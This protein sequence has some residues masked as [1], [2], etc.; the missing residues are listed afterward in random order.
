MQSGDSAR[1]RLE[2]RLGRR[3]PAGLERLTPAEIA[4]LADALDGAHAR[5][6]AALAAGRERALGFIPRFLRGPVRKVV[7]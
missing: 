3:L 6:A 5:E 1:A 7:G 4:R 2:G